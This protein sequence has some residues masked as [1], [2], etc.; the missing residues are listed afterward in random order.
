MGMDESFVKHSVKI[1]RRM[2]RKRVWVLGIP[3]TTERKFRATIEGV[4]PDEHGCLNWPGSL[5]HEYGF[6][7][8]FAAHRLAWAIHHREPVPRGLV[9]DHLCNNPA[10]VN[11]EHLEAVTPSENTV[12]G[13]H[14]RPRSMR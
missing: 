9:V 6:L 14:G 7:G 8:A 5:R 3:P 1:R 4:E 13:N 11:P 2:Y 10:C 12:R